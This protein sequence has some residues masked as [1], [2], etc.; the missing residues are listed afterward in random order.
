MIKSITF[1]EYVQLLGDKSPYFVDEKDED[2]HFRLKYYFPFVHK[3]GNITFIEQT[4]LML[5]VQFMYPNVIF[6]IGTFSGKTAINLQRN[7]DI[8]EIYTMDIPPD[9]DLSQT[10][11][12]QKQN[13]KDVDE[14]GY[15]GEE[16]LFD[17]D[18]PY[19]HQIW[20]DSA[21]FKPGKF[22]NN[23]D[24]MFID[25]SHSYEYAKSD[26]YLA[27]RMVK[28]GGVIFWHDFGYG[29]NSG[30]PGV[31][32]WLEEFNCIQYQEG[33]IRT[34]YAIQG[35]SLAFMFVDNTI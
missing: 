34:I 15:V 2:N 32:Q 31:D 14:L 22:K 19:I 26:T 16:K 30:W 20:C 4:A 27:L 3:S 10:E 6:E 7:H 11:L 24:M 18:D 13:Y 12:E 25:G 5:Y 33:K 28:N 29:H 35:T 8:S 9:S 1:D 21:K 23:I 17:E